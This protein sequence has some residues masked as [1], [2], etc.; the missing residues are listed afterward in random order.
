MKPQAKQNVNFTFILLAFVH[1]TSDFP[2]YQNLGV[3]ALIFLNQAQYFLLT[4]RVFR[5]HAKHI[6]SS[7]ISMPVNSLNSA[8][9]TP[10]GFFYTPYCSPPILDHHIS[11]PHGLSFFFY[12]FCDALKV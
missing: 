4:A 2:L 5:K 6:K 11:F 8:T 3:G 7:N 1:K 12:I 9:S 10:P